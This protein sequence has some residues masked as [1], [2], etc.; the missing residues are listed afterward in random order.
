MFN[1]CLDLEPGTG[2]RPIDARLVLISATGGWP[3]Q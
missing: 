1:Y 2:G 3:P